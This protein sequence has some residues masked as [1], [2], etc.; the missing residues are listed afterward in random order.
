M[1]A[2][3]GA[4]SAERSGTGTGLITAMRQVGATIGV[5]VLGTVINDA[6]RSQLHLAGLPAAAASAV[7]GSVGAGVQV[8]HALGSA[9]VLAV[10]RDAYVHGMDIMLWVCAGVALVSAVLALAFLPR[11]A[12]GASGAAPAPGVASPVDLAQRAELGG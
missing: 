3:I 11:R 9:S 1:N 12:G 4:L 6:Y 2:A 5:A 10:V 8:A 7:R